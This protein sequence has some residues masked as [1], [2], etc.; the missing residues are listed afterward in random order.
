MCRWCV[1]RL[2]QLMFHI[3]YVTQTSSWQRTLSAFF[4][5]CATQQRWE[6]SE[7]L[8]PANKKAP[9]TRYGHVLFI[10][11]NRLGRNCHQSHAT[12][13]T[14][15]TTRAIIKRQPGAA[16]VPSTQRNSRNNPS[17]RW[18]R[19]VVFHYT[20]P[21]TVGSSLTKQWAREQSRRKLAWL[22]GLSTDVRND[23]GEMIPEEKQP[24]QKRKERLLLHR[25]FTL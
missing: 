20:T 2:K 19:D 14:Y 11:C 9:L 21:R 3:Q 23:A 1:R 16:H 17:I 12:T 25:L 5:C 6:G 13:T 15:Q 4:Q 18:A 10:L 22:S 8:H 7:M 24:P